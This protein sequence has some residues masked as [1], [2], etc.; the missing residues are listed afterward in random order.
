MKNMYGLMEILDYNAIHYKMENHD[1]A[2]LNSLTLPV[3]CNY[4]ISCANLKNQPGCDTQNSL[5]LQRLRTHEATP[6]FPHTPQSYE[7]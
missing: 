3:N 7:A 2:C 5:L 4:F 1:M 6:L